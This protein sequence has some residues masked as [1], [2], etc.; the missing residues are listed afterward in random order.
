MMGAKARLF[1]PLPALSID[2]LVPAD[3]FY[4]LPDRV[5]DLAFVRA[6]IAFAQEAFR[7]TQIVLA[8]ATFNRR[9]IT[10]YE[11]RGSRRCGGTCIG[12]TAQTADSRRWRWREWRAP[13][14]RIC[15]PGLIT[16]RGRIGHVARKLSARRAEG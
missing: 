14:S 15:A 11:R 2:E 5:L 7:P 9:A 13:G 12:Q 16:R 6:G 3:H 8:V 4:R 10:V 1:T